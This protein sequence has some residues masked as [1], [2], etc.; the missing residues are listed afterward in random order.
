MLIGPMLPLDNFGSIGGAAGNRTR[1][2]SAYS[3]R[4]YLHS[5]AETGHAQ[6][7]RETLKGK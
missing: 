5:P 1:V 3:V 2:Q 6:Y 4:V 7:R